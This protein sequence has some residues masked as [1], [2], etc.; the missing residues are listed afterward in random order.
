MHTT[1]L[2]DRS[3]VCPAIQELL[4]TQDRPLVVE[5]TEHEPFPDDLAVGLRSLRDRGIYPRI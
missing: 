1:L 2:I 5:I 4:T 3:L